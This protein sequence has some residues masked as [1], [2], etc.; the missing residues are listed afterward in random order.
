MTLDPVKPPGH[1]PT[2]DPEQRIADLENSIG[3]RVCLE[4]I[5]I[6]ASPD[7]ITREEWYKRIGDAVNDAYTDFY[8]QN[9][10][11]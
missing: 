8:K 9:P 2:D 3:R 5:L 10:V 4:M 6:G 11:T 1:L 7:E